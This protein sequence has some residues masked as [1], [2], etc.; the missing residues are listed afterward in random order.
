MFLFRTRAFAAFLGFESRAL[1]RYFHTWGIRGSRIIEDR[2][3]LSSAIFLAKRTR[4]RT[5]QSVRQI[6]VAISVKLPSTMHFA[7]PFCTRPA[8]DHRDVSETKNSK[9]PRAE[10]G[11]VIFHDYLFHFLPC[12]QPFFTF[13]LAEGETGTGRWKE[14][15]FPLSLW[16]SPS[17][18]E[19]DGNADDGCAAASHR[20]IRPFGRTATRQKVLD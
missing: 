10:S 14:E 15:S 8:F 1:D 11:R 13:S 12:I 3:R 19:R 2:K 9:S 18:R 17:C 5:H 16:N 7:I 20:G 4:P 6:R